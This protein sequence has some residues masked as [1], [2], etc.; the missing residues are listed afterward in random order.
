MIAMVTIVSGYY[1]KKKLA[2][3]PAKE[4]SIEVAKLPLSEDTPRQKDI[5]IE[6]A[7]TGT[8]VNSAAMD[9]EKTLSLDLTNVPSNQ[10]IKINSALSGYPAIRFVGHRFNGN[11][12]IDVECRLT[13]TTDKEIGFYW[14]NKVKIHLSLDTIALL[15]RS[16]LGTK[17]FPFLLQPEDAEVA[18][19]APKESRLIT[20]S[21]PITRNM[22]AYLK[23]QYNKALF[24]ERKVFIEFQMIYDGNT[25]RANRQGIWNMFF[26]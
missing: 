7:I 1:F 6:S 21:Y 9:S 14:D 12:W 20:M 26:H 16:Y 17:E 8:Y 22:Y 24:Q 4:L 5:P 25:F 11:Y 13:N 23:E 10:T 3:K 19:L 15:N 2:T 18:P